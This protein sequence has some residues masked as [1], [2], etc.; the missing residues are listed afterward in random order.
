MKRISIH[1]LFSLS[2]LA[3]AITAATLG[4][5]LH[6]LQAL[7]EVLAQVPA[8]MNKHSDFLVPDKFSNHPLVTLAIGN[9]LSAGGELQLAE[10]SFNSLIREHSHTQ[11]GMDARFNLGNAYLRQG[12][13]ELTPANQRG[14]ML[15][16][17]KQRYRDLLQLAPQHWPARY[18]LERALRLAPELASESAAEPIDPVKRVQVIVPGFRKQDLP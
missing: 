17:A 2:A 16:L 13:D 11:S 4:W 1:Q 5:H 14:P 6:K 8:T 3:I 7:K 9:A 18:N 10:R 12:M 15:Q